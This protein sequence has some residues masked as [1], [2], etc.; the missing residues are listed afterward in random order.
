MAFFTIFANPK[1]KCFIYRS[2]QGE[3]GGGASSTSG[4]YVKF[5]G[6]GL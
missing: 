6:K 4:K 5:D 2:K 1:I 3:N